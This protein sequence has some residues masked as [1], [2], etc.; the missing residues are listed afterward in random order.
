MI[1]FTTVYVC[2]SIYNFAY[3]S[4]RNCDGF[5][6]LKTSYDITLS[7]F[8]PLTVMSCNGIDWMSILG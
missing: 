1:M 5:G 7:S 2:F 8:L 4:L 3:F 6:F